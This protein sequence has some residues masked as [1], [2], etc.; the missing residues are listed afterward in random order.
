VSIGQRGLY[1]LGIKTLAKDKQDE[2]KGITDPRHRGEL[3]EPSVHVCDSAKTFGKGMVSGLE[4]PDGC[5][6]KWKRH[7]LWEW[8]GGGHTNKVGLEETEKSQKNRGKLKQSPVLHIKGERKERR[9]TVHLDIPVRKTF[10]IK[11][12]EK[13]FEGGK[14]TKTD[15]ERTC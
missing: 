7:N 6:R 3:N 4:Y 12:V 5:W 9:K 10:P 8:G 11:G 13:T 15:L 14:P 1:Y 2:E